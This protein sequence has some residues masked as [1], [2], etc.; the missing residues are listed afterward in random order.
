VSEADKAGV[1]V[2]QGVVVEAGPG[3][4]VDVELAAAG[5]EA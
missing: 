3:A 2:V 4:V 1:L 5:G